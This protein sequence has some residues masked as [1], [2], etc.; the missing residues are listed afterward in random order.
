[1]SNTAQ[2]VDGFKAIGALKVSA[3]A[4]YVGT[5]MVAT[6]ASSVAEICTI[7]GLPR[8]TVYR[9]QGELFAASGQSLTCLTRPTGENPTCLTRPT[10]ENPTRLTDEKTTEKTVS[11]VPPVRQTGDQNQLDSEPVYITTRATKELPSEVLCEEDI[12]TPHSAPQPKKPPSKTKRGARLPDDWDLPEDWRQWTLVNCPAATQDAVRTEALKFANYWQAQPGAKA[13]KLDW[14][15]T[16]QNWSL[17]AFSRAPLRP[18]A[19]GF[20]PGAVAFQTADERSRERQRALLAKLD[21]QI[22]AAEAQH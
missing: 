19:Q 8:S 12:I 18:T 17:T 13:C 7:T 20:Q 4:K 15:K 1:M 16:W 3:T 9:A 21:S 10:G 5:I 2:D 22:A 14:R 11:L 6:G